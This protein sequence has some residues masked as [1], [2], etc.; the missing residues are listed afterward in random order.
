MLGCAAL[1]MAL[2]TD[3]TADRADDD[4][5]SLSVSDM[6]KSRNVALDLAQTATLRHPSHTPSKQKHKVIRA[7]Y[8]DLES[9]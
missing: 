3:M 7:Q 8:M 5:S 2:T 4:V 1:T 6:Q 9:S